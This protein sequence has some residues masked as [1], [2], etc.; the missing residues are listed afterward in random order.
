MNGALELARLRAQL[1]LAPH[2]GD[3]HV[4]SVLSPSTQ[5]PSEGRAPRG[6]LT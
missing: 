1:S 5:P 2:D 6:D 3:A 4:L